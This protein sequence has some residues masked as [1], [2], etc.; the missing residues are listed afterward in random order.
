MDN[1]WLK[2]IFK[3]LRLNETVISTFL[4]GLVVVVVGVLIYNYFSSINQPAPETAT[5]ADTVTLVEEDGQ[6]V[7][8]SL[9]LK[10]TVMAGDD[11]WHISEKYYESGYNWVDIA[12][13]NNLSNANLIAA[14]Q[15]LTIPRVAVKV[16]TKMTADTQADS[17]SAEEYLVQKGDSLWKISVRAYSDGYAWNKIWEANKELIPN[18]NIIEPGSLLKLP[19]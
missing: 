12:Q 14:G 11:L 2:N 13:E 16:S 4:G 8:E 9:P 7:P 6:M 3:N 18:P 10:H 5:I 17:I 15:E 1:L 19:R